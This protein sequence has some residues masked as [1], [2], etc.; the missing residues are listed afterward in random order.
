MALCNFGFAE[1]FYG[2][3]SSIFHSV[4]VSIFVNGSPEGYFSCSYG[5]HKE[6]PLSH[7]LFSITEDFISRYLTF[8]DNQ[9]SISPMLSS[10]DWCALSHLLYTD[11]I[12][13]FFVKIQKQT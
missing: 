2:W 8:L 5:V 3:I 11:N 12:L 4:R 1:S 9:D 10:R 6:D 13:F 7:L